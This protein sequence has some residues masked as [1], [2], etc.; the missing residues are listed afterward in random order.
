MYPRYN[1]ELCLQDWYLDGTFDWMEMGEEYA[2]IE[3]IEYAKKRIH[4]FCTEDE[5]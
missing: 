4:W 5:K 2:G 3:Q 1:V